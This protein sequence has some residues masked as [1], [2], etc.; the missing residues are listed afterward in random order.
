MCK[1]KNSRVLALLAVLTIGDGIMGA[2]YTKEYMKQWRLGPKFMQ[3]MAKYFL[4]HLIFTKVIAILETIA[5]FWIGS[6]VR[7]NRF[8]F[9]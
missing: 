8:K 6:R 2:V 1:N 5:G 3:K 4:K 9:M 7:A